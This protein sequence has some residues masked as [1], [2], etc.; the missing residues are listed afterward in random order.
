[1]KIRPPRSIDIIISPWPVFL[2]SD[3]LVGQDGILRAGL[4]T[5]AGR[6][7]NPPQV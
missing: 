4:R 5:G 7:A 2:S 6:V 3:R 1:M